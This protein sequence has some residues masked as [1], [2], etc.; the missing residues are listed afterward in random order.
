MGELVPTHSG[1]ARRKRQRAAP[2]EHQRDRSW[3]SQAPFLPNPHTQ[4]KRPP[5][6]HISHILPLHIAAR[7]RPQP[8]GWGACARRLFTAY[9]C[10][11]PCWRSSPLPDF[12]LIRRTPFYAFFWAYL[13]LVTDDLVELL[14]GLDVGRQGDGGTDQGQREGRRGIHN[15]IGEQQSGMGN[16]RLF[17]GGQKGTKVST[18]GH[19]RDAHK[20]DGPCVRS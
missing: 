18:L 9:C 6:T 3:L 16:T 10:V 20:H 17:W 11:R 4:K 8:F 13:A 12:L 2:A 19:K 5:H 14:A 1:H 7:A 15:S